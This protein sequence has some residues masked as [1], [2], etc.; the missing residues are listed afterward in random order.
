[1]IFLFDNFGREATRRKREVKMR[2]HFPFCYHVI[3]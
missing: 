2:L 3:E 1:M